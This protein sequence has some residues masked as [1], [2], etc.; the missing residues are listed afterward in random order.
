[1]MKWRLTEKLRLT[2][3]LIF[4]EKLN[5]K[6]CLVIGLFLIPLSLA[7]HPLA[8]FKTMTG[9]VKKEQQ[10]AA[11]SVEQGSAAQ[12]VEEG[13]PAGEGGAAVA[14]R[15]GEVNRSDVVLL[16][17]VIEGEAAEEPYSGKVAV[18]AVIVNRTKNP[19]FPKTIPG[20]VYERDAFE[21]VSNGQYLRPVT[22]EAL[23]AATEAV[24]GADPVNGALYFWNPAKSSSEWVYTRPIITRIGG[25]VFAR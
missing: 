12:P 2:K 24:N 6:I 23:Q 18:G 13:R 22:N 7:L 15:G 14:S 1:M 9:P 10:A 3:K 21:S 25:H 19:D 4:K 5:K 8:L 11:L 17:Q 16:A 20:V